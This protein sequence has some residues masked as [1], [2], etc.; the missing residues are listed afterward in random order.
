MCERNGWTHDHHRRERNAMPRHR[1]NT[2][3]NYNDYDYYYDLSF[4]MAG[5]GFCESAQQ[6]KT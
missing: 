2:Q 4:I 3:L 6:K 5:I 1:E